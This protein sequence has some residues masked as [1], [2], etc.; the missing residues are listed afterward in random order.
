[1]LRPSGRLTVFWNIFDPPADLRA[2]FDGVYR[3]VL[4]GS[5]IGGLWSLPTETARRAMTD[6]AGRGIRQAGTFGPPEQ[7]RFDWSRPYTREE[8]LTVVP[9]LGAHGEFPPA[10]LAELLAGLGDVIDRA[11][12]TVVMRYL[13]VAVMAAAVGADRP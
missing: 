13:T 8:W 4:P 11:G 5:P 2:A 12:G 3:R 9:T 10:V 7:W 6:T 1:M